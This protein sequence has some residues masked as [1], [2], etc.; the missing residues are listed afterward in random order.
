MGYIKASKEGLSSLHSDLSTLVSSLDKIKGDLDSF[1]QEASSYAETWYDLYHS[2]ACNKYKSSH[3]PCEDEYRAGRADKSSPRYNDDDIDKKNPIYDYSWKSDSNASWTIVVKNQLSGLVSDFKSEAEKTTD[4]Y[5]KEKIVSTISEKIQKIISCIE[6]FEGKNISLSEALEDMKDKGYHVTTETIEID[7][8][9]VEVEVYKFTDTDGNE[10]TV[11]EM[12]NAYY[13][14]IG[15]V[16]NGAVALASSGNFVDSNGNIIDDSFS[17]ALNN[18]VNNIGA[19]VG[20]Y[21]KN[22]FFSVV[23][24]SHLESMYGD[25]VGGDYGK[26]ADDYYSLINTFSD[27]DDTYETYLNKKTNA[28]RSGFMELSG[29]VFGMGAYKLADYKASESGSSNEV[30]DPFDG[31]DN[32]GRN[33]S[34]NGGSSSGGGNSGGSGNYSGGGSGSGGSSG[35]GTSGGGG[36]GSDP[37]KDK[38]KEPTKD[39]DKDPTKDKDK[40]PTKDKDKDPTKDKDKDP[41]KNAEPP[42]EVTKQE[43]RGNLPE[44]V[45]TDLGTKDYDELAREQFEAQGDAKIA[46]NRAKITEEANKLFEAEDKTELINKLK[47]YGYTE[48]DINDIIQD[49]NL[50]T[51]ALIEG[52]QRQQLAT[53]A[54]NLAKADGVKDFDTAYDEGQCCHGFYDGSSEAL[55]SNASAD[56]TVATAKTALTDATTKYTESVKTAQESITKV[57]EAQKTVETTK[58]EIVK[59]VASDTKNWSTT[60]QTKYSTE[61][62][63]AQDAFIKKNGDA[64]KWDATK[65]NEYQ[66]IETNLKNKYVSEIQKDSSKWS[67]DQIEK[68]NKSVENYNTALKDANTKYEASQ[69]AK[70]S[71]ET[72]KANYE[73]ARETYLKNVQN[74]NKKDT[75]NSSV[76]TD[77]SL[78]S[79]GVQDP[80]TNTGSTSANT[81]GI[82]DDQLL[83]GVNSNGNGASLG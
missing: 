22:G 42:V 41:T 76:N 12:V 51:S 37:T 58:A 61:L 38:D 70:T 81:V 34:N 47:E 82:S 72:S 8:E 29:L 45:E 40:D 75:Y 21:L 26:T 79:N 57:N 3:T 28:D 6:K 60:Q 54:N 56:P 4:F 35:G 23:S 44:K 66:K 1:S 50:V 73:K 83:N 77:T 11:S 80:T 16:G 9:K 53:M 49:R 5:D 55:L 7:G 63:T 2:Q 74:A 33:G 27:N 71:Y 24:N 43:E 46:E 10:Y 30:V 65:V 69:T 31:S 48:I 32:G 59:S 15:T 13:T 68:Y 20:G 52:D 78:P 14:Y 62:K 17:S 67:N 64:T 39:K 36:S 18:G 19:T 25:L